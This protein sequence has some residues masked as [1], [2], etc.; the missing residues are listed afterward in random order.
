MLGELFTRR[1][2]IVIGKGGVGKT[3]LCAALARVAAAGGVLPLVMQCDARARSNGVFEVAPTFE[4]RDAGHGVAI[5]LLDG[6]QALQE[7]LRLVVPGRA[8][9]HAVFA[10]RLYRFFVQAAP[11]VKELMMLGKVCYEL[12]RRTAGGEA[13]RYESSPGQSQS[14]SHGSGDGAGTS[15]RRWGL[16]IVDAPA[17]GQALSLLRMPFA[18]RQT[19]G[20][21]I[22]G[23]EAEKIGRT[24]RDGRTT[25]I[26]QVT[27]PEPLAVAETLETFAALAEMKLRPAAIL[28]NRRTPVE[29]DEADIASL[30]E[31]ARGGAGRS[32][33]KEIARAELAR[34]RAAT[35]AMA[36]LRDRTRVP[37]IE[38][39]DY[40]GISPVA[41]V[42]RIGA[43]LSSRLEAES[44]SRT[45]RA[46]L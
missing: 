9:L 44:A 35:E 21:S 5:S 27:T 26:V 2:L 14:G 36:T 34:R 17:S 8:L 43:Q 4:P 28:C 46:A 38:V 23:R 24:L 6:G 29:F 30:A 11:G 37:V 10:S 7:Y 33:V 22:V 32:H 1:L 45:K 12:E 40:P 15:T 19:F 39:R 18:A 42:E 3:S 13:A 31:S 41:L 25:A 20:E 16:I